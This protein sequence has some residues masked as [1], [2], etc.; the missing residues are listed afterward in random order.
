M[1]LGATLTVLAGMCLIACGS[2]TKGSA[3]VDAD[4]VRYIACGGVVSLSGRGNVYDPNTRNY[5]VLFTDPQG[6]QHD[7]RMVRMLTIT[8]LPKNSLAC[9]SSGKPDANR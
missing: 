1:R 8:P 5:E 6:K 4:G 9:G 7:L 2:G 3:I